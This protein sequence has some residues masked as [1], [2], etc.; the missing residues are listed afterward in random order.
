MVIFCP[1]EEGVIVGERQL[2]ELLLGSKQ[3]RDLVELAVALVRPLK[4]AVDGDGPIRSWHL[5]LEVGIMRNCH[6]FGRSWS[7]EDHMV[8][9]KGSLHREQKISYETSGRNPKI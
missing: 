9:L 5:E 1:R 4:V 6:E 8:L 3:F 7:P 2:L